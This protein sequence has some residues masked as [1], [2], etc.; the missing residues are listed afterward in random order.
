[1]R[2][3]SPGCDAIVCSH[4]LSSNGVG[5]AWV[6]WRLFQEI[7][8][9][10]VVAGP[11]TGSLWTPLR[12]SPFAASCIRVGP[13]LDEVPESLARRADSASIAVGVKPLRS[14]LG[15]AERLAARH[16]LALLADIDD[17]DFAARSTSIPFRDVL[18][19]P[20]T[21]WRRGRS[22]RDLA[23]F[24]ALARSVPRMVSNPTLHEAY[25]GTVVPHV[26]DER[27]AG[28]AHEGRHP[29]VCFV[30]TVRPH[31][32]IEL[33]RDAVARAYPEPRL[34]VTA[35]PPPDARPWEVWTGPLAFD[36]GMQLVDRSDIVAVPSTQG[37]WSTGQFPVKLLDAMMSGRA[38][39]ASDNPVHRWVLGDTALLVPPGSVE[40]L[41]EALVR[42]RDPDLR[43][44]LG[45][46]AR[47]RVLRHFTPAAVAQPFAH[48]VR[49]QL[50][51]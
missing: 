9:D 8:L 10:A 25:G 1:M 42:L 47:R 36:D 20:R 17:P 6:V 22:N 29:Q 34:A 35:E 48:L 44:T 39:V 14:S 46:D 2:D 32:G 27:A 49:E 24:D 31:K 16:G 4:D 30:G 15:F 21:S 41:V 19:H 3:E 7:G 12:D 23:R 40:A 37:A 11:S 38:I 51:P 50:R 5:R 43:R 28:T 45:A 18:A 33:L 26:R 13:S